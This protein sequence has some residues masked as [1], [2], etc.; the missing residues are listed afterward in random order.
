[1]RTFL[2]KIPSANMNALDAALRTIPPFIGITSGGGADAATFYF[3]DSATDEQLNQAQ[4]VIQAHDP[5]F[6]GV[7]RSV[8]PADG[9][10]PA[11]VSVQVERQDAAPVVLLFN[12]ISVPV[13]LVNNQGSITLTAV[14]AVPVTISVQNS[15]N[16]CID[17]LTI[18][19]S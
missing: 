4:G 7:S 18:Q 2:M 15:A 9:V 19:V 6:V 16:R 5:V 8:L 11:I 13:P 12:G 14:A 3:N 17:V 1:M 10:T